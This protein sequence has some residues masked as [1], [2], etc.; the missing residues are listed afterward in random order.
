LS[1]RSSQS[2]SMALY[3][4]LVSLIPLIAALA[5]L[6]LQYNVGPQTLLFY[7]AHFSGVFALLGM[8]VGSALCIIAMAR[9]QGRWDH[10]ISLAIAALILAGVGL[11]LFRG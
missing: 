11:F 10:R 4:L 6:G 1:H 5:L 7:L 3:A 2:N 9:S 8:V